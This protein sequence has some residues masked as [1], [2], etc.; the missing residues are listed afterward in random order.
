MRPR[1]VP[2]RL[3]F[4]LAREAPVGVLFRRGPS[5][6]GRL[7]RWDLTN[8]VFEPGQW[9]HGRLYERRADLSPDGTLLVYF[10]QKIGHPL[11]R[12]IS[13]CAYSWTAVSHPRFLTALALWP[14]GDCWAG[15]GS[16]VD[17]RTLALNH[18]AAIPHPE[19]DPRE[20]LHVI[21]RHHGG[22][23]CPLF[24]ARLKRNG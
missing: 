3:Y 12:G 15:S 9:F 16:F 13:V 10:A 17:N 24:D 21:V 1:S 8:D 6:W 22:E 19:H 23:D 18:P 4:L 20:H 5:R 2:C 11:M 14:K 7:I